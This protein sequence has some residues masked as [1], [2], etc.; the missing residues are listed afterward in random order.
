MDSAYLKY[1]VNKEGYTLGWLADI[2][3]INPAT[4]NRKMSGESDF[5]RSE[6]QI[7]KANLKLSINEVEAIFFTE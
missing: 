7:I 1:W 2:V 4:L 3:G 5:T 6:I